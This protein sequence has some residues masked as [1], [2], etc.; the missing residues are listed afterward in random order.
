MGRI[1][2]LREQSNRMGSSE[3]LRGQGIPDSIRDGLTGVAGQI[4]KLLGKNDEIGGE[5]DDED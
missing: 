1:V 4:F 5:R 3:A 2:D